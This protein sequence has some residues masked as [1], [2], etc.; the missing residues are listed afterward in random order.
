MAVLQDMHSI[1]VRDLAEATV[2]RAVARVKEVK[3][4]DSG[5]VAIHLRLD[6]SFGKIPGLF[7]EKI[8][9]WG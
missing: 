7:E 8:P 4:R 1:T 2:L 5:P 3:E 9:L 6:P